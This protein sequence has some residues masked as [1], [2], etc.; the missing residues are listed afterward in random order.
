MGFM[1]INALCYAAQTGSIH[2]AR[3]LLRANADVNYDGGFGCTPMWFAVRHDQPDFLRFLV[4]ANADLNV[5][6]ELMTPVAGAA[7]FGCVG[8][9]STLL[10]LKA[11]ADNADRNGWTPLMYAAKNREV[12]CARL[13]I[14]AHA[15]VNVIGPEQQYC[16]APLLH[17]ASN[18]DLAMAALLVEAK[19]VVNIGDMYRNTPLSLAAAQGHVAMGQLLLG[20]KADVGA[21]RHRP[22]IQEA[23]ARGHADMVQLLL[24]ANACLS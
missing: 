18:G 10:E 2:T 4:D 8:A 13:L 12:S 24:G 15:Q 21:P 9:V 7:G 3:L 16:L 5:V 20:A 1:G 17:A 14:E 23:T 11:Q 6:N 19:A 22:A